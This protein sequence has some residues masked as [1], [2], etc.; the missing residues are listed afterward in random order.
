[1]KK[2]I[3]LIAALVLSTST[4]YTQAN[5][6]NSVEYPEGTT[7]DPYACPGGT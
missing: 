7:I 4:T 2:V 5:M 6:H 3:S 1:M